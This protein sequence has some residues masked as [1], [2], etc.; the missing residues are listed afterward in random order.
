MIRRYLAAFIAAATL[1]SLSFVVAGAT[2]VQYG[3]A[4]ELATTISSNYTDFGQVSCPALQHCVAVGIADESGVDQGFA[5]SQDGTGWADAVNV[6]DG[7]ANSSYSQLQGVDC[8]SVGNCVA[9]GQ[10]GDEIDQTAYESPLIVDEVNGVWQAPIGVSR[11]LA[12]ISYMYLNYVSCSTAGNCV[13][14]GQVDNGGDEPFIVQETDGTWGT[15]TTL[16]MWST[17][18]PR[19]GAAESV[20]CSSNGNCVIV[21]EAEDTRTNG[22]ADVETNGTWADPITL[23]TGLGQWSELTS[24]SCPTDGNCTAVGESESST[25][26]L[27]YTGYEINEVN[28]TWGSAT[29]V[30]SSPTGINSSQLNSVSC[31]APGDCTATGNAHSGQFVNTD[32]RAQRT[33]SRL[34]AHG[35]EAEGYQILAVSE[36]GGTWQT[37][38]ILGENLNTGVEAIGNSVSC[39][40]VGDCLLTGFVDSTH[41]VA[42]ADVQTAGSWDSAVAITSGLSTSDSSM[43]YDASCASSGACAVGG[44]YSPD[45]D[46][47]WATAI[48]I[49]TVHAV[50][51]IDPFNFN[52]ATLTPALR[53]QVEAAAQ[54]IVTEG[55]TN[56][57]AT[58]YTDSVGSA[59][60][61]LKLSR[62]RAVVVTAQ[63]QADLHAL[64]D[65]SVTVTA[66]GK[67]ATHFVASN[68]T[69]AGRAKNRRVALSYSGST[70]V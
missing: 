11:T 61:N 15:P 34:F 37:G 39:A 13:A 26:D 19:F 69:A 33:D 55:F 56:V 47:A 31:A 16:P 22:F 66:T 45:D 67:G 41:Y 5:Q 49:P 70:P 20:S 4:T 3:T 65:S 42:V 24:V 50:A 36:L 43:G 53:A 44:W 62:A 6:V 9:V 25:N 64:G 17:F 28:G 30:D 14:I 8:P 23:L 38:Q 21:G 18:S 2:T 46:E 35:E 60:Y 27:V 29:A 59:S 58:G 48:S 68:A 10:Y 12:G 52:H 32:R 7:L 51:A 1:S 57:A 40:A 63:L 54:Y